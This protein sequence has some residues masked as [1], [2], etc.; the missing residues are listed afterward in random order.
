MLSASQFTSERAPPDIVK[1][2]G[3][4]ISNN[5]LRSREMIIPMLDRTL[6]PAER[7]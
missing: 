5:G 6:I 3:W 2:N 7:L 4:K 1:E